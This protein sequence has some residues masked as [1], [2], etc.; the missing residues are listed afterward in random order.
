M[1][2]LVGCPALVAGLV[3]LRF[4]RGPPSLVAAVLNPA[5][6]TLPLPPASSLRARVRSPRSHP[7]PSRS[8]RSTGVSASSVSLSPLHSF[9]ATGALGKLPVS[10]SSTPLLA[11]AVPPPHAT[12]S[13]GSGATVPSLLLA[14]SQVAGLPPWCVFSSRPLLGPTPSLVCHICGELLP[15]T[16]FPV[17]PL[18]SSGAA[19]P[20]GGPAVAL[21]RSAEAS[22]AWFPS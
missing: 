14:F 4:C 7:L 22:R 2:P 21:P 6:K 16:S 12:A 8:C 19:A 3:R 5:P 9:R 18:P 20:L 17:H 15:G 11:V 1:P 10:G 13:C